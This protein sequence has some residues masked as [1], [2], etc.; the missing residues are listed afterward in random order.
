MG[1]TLIQWWIQG[2]ASHSRPRL[3]SHSFIFM[4]FWAKIL[5]NNRLA[6]APLELAPI[7]WE[8]LDPPLL[9]YPDC[10]HHHWGNVKTLTIMVNGT[11]EFPSKKRLIVIDRWPFKRIENTTERANKFFSLPRDRQIELPQIT[12]ATSVVITWWDAQ[13]R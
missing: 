8:I 1:S 13:G 11:C 7:P 3:S 6:H 9:F 4:Q 5:Q 12:G 2:G 10:Y